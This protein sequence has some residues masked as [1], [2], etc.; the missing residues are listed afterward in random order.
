[1]P[2]MSEKSPISEAALPASTPSVKITTHLDK[3][4]NYIQNTASLDIGD[5]D[6]RAVRRK[7]DFRL[8]PV[9][10]MVYTMQV[11][12]KVNVNY[13]AVMGFN[14][15]LHLKGNNFSDATTAF[16]V[17]VLIAEIPNGYFLQKI[18]AGK[19]LGINVVLWGITTCCFAGVT[20]YSTL[21]TARIFLGI[22]ESC[23]SPCLM[24][25]C[26]QWYTRSE[27][28]SRFQFW[29]MGLPVAQIFGG[30]ISFAFQ[31]VENAALEGWRVMFLTLGAV[32]I[33]IGAG[34][35]YVL[36]DSPMEVQWLQEKEKKALLLH[37][38]ENRTGVEN[39]RFEISQL[40]EL[41]FDP[42][43]W[44]LTLINCLIAIS[45]GVIN[46]YSSTIIKQ[47]GYTS[48]EA[49]L[50]NMPSGL[51]SFTFALLVG[52]GIRHTSN[53]WAWLLSCCFPAILGGALMS[54]APKHNKP[55]L[56]TGVYLV[57]AI[58]PTIIIL[59]QWTMCN[60]AGHTKRAVASVVVAGGFGAGSIIGPQ[61]FRKEDAPEYHT[62]KVILMATQAS[63]AGVTVVLFGYYVWANRGK[64][65]R[66]RK[67]VAEGVVVDGTED[68]WGNL[69]DRKNPEFSTQFLSMSIC[70]SL[71]GTSRQQTITLH[72]DP[73]KVRI[74]KQSHQQ[75]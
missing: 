67:L 55:A 54:F 11:L 27:A 73:K 24:L 66:E 48:K 3:A 37:I 50:L 71:N 56:L 6:I 29:F 21:L 62:A 5:V 16:S 2:S 15:D 65:R 31:H 41:V 51:I 49:A 61:T 60:V 53:R 72:N 47:F 39:R 10:L 18:P 8:I 68:T 34:A 12:D 58:T 69:T 35:L 30:L 32:T 14:Q 63:A 75:L 22:F 23:S 20:N 33:L 17:A 46:A 1:M 36:P 26:S 52:F 57:N 38:S 4:Y 44:L 42:Q 43:I 64:E 45:S 9:M 25:L 7:V 59:Y 74:H 70:F 13:A 28:A 40:R 19:W